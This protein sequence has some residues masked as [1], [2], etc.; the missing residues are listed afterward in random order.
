MG[1]N[2]NYKMPDKIVS[3]EYVNIEG[4]T[5]TGLLTLGSDSYNKTI[6]WANTD[7]PSASAIA[8]MGALTILDAIAMGY[9]IVVWLVVMMILRFIIFSIKDIKG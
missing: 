7:Y 3:D 6:K 9:A 5:M 2:D 1:T 8:F 4:D